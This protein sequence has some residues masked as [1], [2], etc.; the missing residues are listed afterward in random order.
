[1]LHA[2]QNLAQSPLRGAVANS[3][4][5]L[6]QAMID[7]ARKPRAI[8]SAIAEGV[9]NATPSEAFNSRATRDAAFPPARERQYK[10]GLKPAPGVKIPQAMAKPSARHA[11]MSAS[12]W[13]GSAL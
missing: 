8:V 12:G 6:V 11:C 10:D 7:Q 1:M 2:F 4:G 5:N 3:A 13:V 9:L